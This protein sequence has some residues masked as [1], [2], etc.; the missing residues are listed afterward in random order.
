MKNIRRMNN[1]KNDGFLLIS[2]KGKYFSKKEKLKCNI[3]SCIIILIIISIFL[4]IY[5][6]FLIFNTNTK[7]NHNKIINNSDIKKSIKKVEN[8][9]KETG[10]NSYYRTDKEREEAIEKGKKFFSLC[11]NNVLINNK[12]ITKEKNPFISVIIP[13]YNTE[14]RLWSVIRSVQNQNISNIEIVLINDFSNNKTNEVIEQMIKEDPRILLIN[15]KKNMGTLYSRCIGALYSNGKYIFYLDN[16]DLFFDEGVLDII[17]SEAEKGDFDIVEF[18]G[19]ERYIFNV[20]SMNFKDSE[21]SNHEHNLI[22]RQPEL[23]Q[24]A[25]R[26]NNIFGIYDCF[27]W[28]KCIKT[29]VYK[30]TV[31]S[32]G[33]K[34]YSEYII[35]GEDLIA[36]FVLFRIAQS[37]KFISMYGISRFKSLSTASNRTP[38]QIFYLSKI[39][40]IK[41]LLEH[42]ENNFYDKKI[43]SHEARSLMLHYSRMDLDNKKYLK[44]LLKSII[45]NDYVSNSDKD[46]L[47]QYY[48]KFGSIN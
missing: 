9:N 3:I 42:T 23:G 38:P 34:I 30:K 13:V 2:T 16:D 45:N 25:R 10:S 48:K 47:R 29:D 1:Y 17:S 18:K 28:A 7:K 43:L 31:N 36:S 20:F 21:Y 35:W 6:F 12:T 27:I 40:Y 5:A 46:I 19:A 44:E 32:I 39:L 24:Y 22:L 26:K 15:N 8:I 37:F 4:M 14:N 41:I 11:M 33:S